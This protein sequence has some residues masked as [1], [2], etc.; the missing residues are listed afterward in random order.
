M[1]EFT[2]RRDPDTVD[3]I[4]MLEHPSVY[5]L[6]LNGN[7]EHL[8]HPTHV[9]V[10]STDRGGQITWHGPGQ[11]IAYTLIDLR[12]TKLGIRQ[13]V[14][15]LQNATLEV[16]KTFGIQGETRADA[17]GI[18]VDGAKIASVGLRIIRGCSY[19][20]ISLNIDADLGGFTYINPCGF[21]KLPVTSLARLGAHATVAEVIPPFTVALMDALGFRVAST[22]CRKLPPLCPSN[23]LNHHEA[24]R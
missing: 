2:A 5:T 22:P 8:I 24:F 11:L 10:V 13:L 9:P 4:W 3:E 18:Y 19:H 14:N 15:L 23:F 1:R 17:P 7:P 20:G 12:R 6:G 16:L 21:P